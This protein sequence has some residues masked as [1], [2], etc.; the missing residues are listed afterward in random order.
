MSHRE[1][2]NQDICVSV[3]IPVYNVENY[4]KAC[5]Q[6]VQK[7]NIE[8]IEIIC[9]EDCSTD[10]SLE[11]LEACAQED[12]RI[13]ILKNK[14]NEGLS[15]SRNRGMLAARGSY[16]MFVDSDDLLAENALIELCDYMSKHEVNAILFNMTTVLEGRAAR[17]K[18]ENTEGQ[19][20]QDIET[21]I[22]NRGELLGAF[23]KIRD[24]KVEAFRYFWKREKLLQTGI[25]FYPG[26]IHEDNLFSFYAWMEVDKI[27]YLKREY[28]IYRKRDGSIMYSHSYRQVESLFIIFDEILHYW[29]EHR[30]SDETDDAIRT[31]LDS[32]Y[33]KFLQ[34]KIYFEKYERI[35]LGSP[36]D[37][38]L[39]EKMWLQRQS[40]FSYAFLSEDKIQRLKNASKVIIYGAGI[41][42]GEAI[43][44]LEQEGIRISAVA[45]T[46][47]E[48]NSTTI[49]G[50]DIKNICSLKSWNKNAMVLLAAVE[51]HHGSML[52]VLK[53]QGF[54][55]VMVFDSRDK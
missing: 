13:V 14:K 20:T 28:Y 26:L 42:G 7:Q 39:Y 15:Y 27:A 45:V 40:A 55:N 5:L 35:S 53:E 33:R 48:N 12:K 44:L 51:R 31:Y 11:V 30:F 50:Y 43:E 29:K 41:V 17:E 1:T 34:K 18:L 24:W 2:G 10:G 9:V 16:L 25:Q 38:Y 46:N 52:R 49:K 8:E 37:A 36:A 23:S 22:Y 4:L 19:Y 32:I 3:I 47:P 54:E 21:G 6:S